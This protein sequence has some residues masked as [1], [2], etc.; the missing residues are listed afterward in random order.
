MDSIMITE[1][2]KP[3]SQ[4]IITQ[5]ANMLYDE[6]DGNMKR[7]LDDLKF[8]FEENNWNVLCLKHDNQIIG[9]ALYKY[10]PLTNSVAI[11]YVVIEKSFRGRGLGTLLT[12]KIEEFALRIKAE[13]IFFESYEPLRYRLH[14]F[15]EKLGYRIAKLPLLLP[16]EPPAMYFFI[17]FL[18]GQPK[19]APEYY[20]KL[21]R[22]YIQ[23]SYY[24]EE[25]EKYSQIFE[26][27]FSSIRTLNSIQLTTTP[28]LVPYRN[29][30]YT[31]KPCKELSLEELKKF[32]E[33]L[34]KNHL[35]IFR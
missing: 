33:E 13:S 9:F 34:T 19:T 2:K 20:E 15:I 25:L 8:Y 30:I 32:V 16:D 18:R 7:W 10:L 12:R 4:K 11:S 23:E 1:I 21:L 6:W 24:E 5:F 35:T 22:E 26:L 14:F 27:M 28:F 3:V 29:S 17:K 31:K